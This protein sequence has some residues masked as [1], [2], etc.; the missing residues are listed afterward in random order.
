[1]L[2]F[3]QKKISRF[4]IGTLLHFWA[5][6]QHHNEAGKGAFAPEAIDFFMEDGITVNPKAL[7]LQET[8]DRGESHEHLKLNTR[9]EWDHFIVEMG[10]LPRSEQ[11]FFKLPCLLDFGPRGYHKHGRTILEGLAFR[12][13]YTAFGLL[14]DDKHILLE[15]MGMAQAFINA[16]KRGSDQSAKINIVI[17]LS[18]PEDIEKNG[19]DYTRDVAVHFPGVKLLPVADGYNAPWIYFTK[20]D[21]FHTKA[22]DAIGQH[23]ALRIV[24][25][26]HNL[27][28]V[29][30]EKEQATQRRVKEIL[31]DLDAPAFI[32]KLPREIAFWSNFTMT[33]EDLTSGLMGLT[34][35]SKTTQEMVLRQIFSRLVKDSEIGAWPEGKFDE[36]KM[37]EDFPKT[38]RFLSSPVAKQIS[39]LWKE[40]KGIDPEWLRGLKRGLLAEENAEARKEMVKQ[41]TPFIS[42]KNVLDL[43]KFSTE[44]ENRKKCEDLKDIC[45]DFFAKNFFEIFKKPEFKEFQKARLSLVH[46]AAGRIKTDQINQLDDAGFTLL[47]YAVEAEDIEL[48]KILLAKKADPNP[49]PNSKA[50]PTALVA[51]GK[52][53]KELYRLL[54]DNGFKLLKGLK[55]L[56]LK[57]N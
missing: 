34:P 36:S 16:T 39:T 54:L 53:N 8:F 32:S 41:A 1:L 51:A 30:T 44:K 27:P 49:L 18:S 9:E 5:A 37:S 21:L 29:G 11:Q 25:T 4:Q 20:H 43:L 45:M 23:W 6:I 47:D 17:G 57:R 40:Q 3:K 19:F 42:S 52:G 55:Y 13:G 22:E 24:K 48:V 46:V 26:W 33:V 2:A 35:L 7:P 28:F 15:T 12:A 31:N 38:F 56:I 50:K 14:Q 10:K